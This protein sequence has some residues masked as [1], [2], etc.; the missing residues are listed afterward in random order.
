[1]TVDDKPVV[2][3]AVRLRSSSSAEGAMVN[4]NR[5]LAEKM[6]AVN[7]FATLIVLGPRVETLAKSCATWARALS[8]VHARTRRGV[9]PRTSG[10]CQRRPHVHIRHRERARR[11]DSRRERCR[12]GAFFAAN[13][14]ASYDTLRE[15]LAPLESDIG[16]PPYAERGLS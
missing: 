14:D 7:V 8:R 3:E 2:V 12:R 13:T 9:G 1:M 10:I 15:I 11:G 16:A 5:S 4:G 6:G